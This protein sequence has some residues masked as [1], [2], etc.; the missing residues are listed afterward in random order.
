MTRPAFVPPVDEVRSAARRAGG[1]PRRLMARDAR[2]PS[3]TGA[4]TI[5]LDPLCFNGTVTR[6]AGHAIVVGNSDGIGLA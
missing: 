4:V 1:R 3:R 5:L 6:P 2:H